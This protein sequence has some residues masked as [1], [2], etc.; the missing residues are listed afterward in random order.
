M[1]QSKKSSLLESVTNLVVGYLLAII[2]QLIVFPWFDLEP[3]LGENAAIAM[4]FSIV[5]VARSYGLRRLF[6]MLDAIAEMADAD[7]R[8]C[9]QDSGVK[10]SR[11]EW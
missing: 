1:S 5:S 10:V 11:W 4:I 8:H 7:G 2:T 6:V 3:T 9:A